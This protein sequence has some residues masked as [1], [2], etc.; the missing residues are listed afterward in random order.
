MNKCFAYKTQGR[1][2]FNCIALKVSVCPGKACP[3]YKT[4]EQV[5]EEQEKSRLR[6]RS[7]LSQDG[8]E[9]IAQKYGRRDLF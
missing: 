7:V 6:L 2:G 5:R 4:E 1:K 3:F 9:Y 8:K